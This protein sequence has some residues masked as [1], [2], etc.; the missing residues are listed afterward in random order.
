MPLPSWIELDPDLVYALEQC[1]GGQPPIVALETAVLTHGL[2]EPHNR[3]V[4]DAMAQA[5]REA[6]GLP[7]IIALAEGKV[8]IGAA[9]WLLD[10]LQQH[11]VAMKVNPGNM[12]VCLAREALGGTTVAATVWAAAQVGIRVMATG[13]IGGRH[14]PNKRT[15]H[16]VSADLAMLAREQVVVVSSGVKSILDVSGTR[17]E[18]ETRGVPVLGLGCDRMPLFWSPPEGPLIDAR[19]DSVAEAAVIARKHLALKRGGLLLAVPCPP[20]AA[21]RCDMADEWMRAVQTAIVADGRDETPAML[22]ALDRAS[23]GTTRAANTA[24]L[25]NNAKIATELANVL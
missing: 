16:D 7:A 1:P 4:V 19:V 9:S 17:E 23:N 18:L 20:E 2:P 10:R 13:G 5:V 6:G 3:H 11:G 24:L 25:V 8:V 21:I 15:S 22:S 14:K 12:A